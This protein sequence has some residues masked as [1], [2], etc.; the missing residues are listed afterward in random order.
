MSVLDRVAAVRAAGRLPLAVLDVDLTL[1][2][3]APRT[4]AIL[5][6][7]LLTLRG[8]WPGADAAIAAAQT[9][10]IGFSALR[11]VR[12]LGVDDEAL[13][14]EGLAFWWE[15]FFTARYAALDVPCPG[16]VEAARRLHGAGATL[17]Y[18]TARPSTLADATANRFREFG[19]PIAEV[20]TVLVMKDE[21]KEPDGAFK[22]RALAWIGG[23]GEVVLCAD[24]EPAHVNAMRAAFPA[25][26]A[27]QVTTRHSPDA[28][29]LAAG[30]RVVARLEDVL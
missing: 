18:L 6:D 30:A 28:P 16:A 19:L 9:M 8:R 4:R 5:V 13:L 23:L 3:N 20:G 2:D 1:V 15:R 29:A 14:R 11:N 24:N 10:P 25:A 7:W 27:V 17:V 21:P 22:S 26:L 12:A